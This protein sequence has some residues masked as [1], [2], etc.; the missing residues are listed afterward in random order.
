MIRTLRGKKMASLEGLFDEAGAALQLPY[1][2]GENWAAFDECLKDLSWLPGNG[3]L[4]V[5]LNADAILTDEEPEQLG[6]LARILREVCKEWS[7]PVALGESWDRPAKPFHVLWH[8][9]PD[10]ITALKGRTE[11]IG[12]SL[13]NLT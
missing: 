3:Y 12:L 1:Y 11:S 13:E 10:R 2:F 4:I 5:L 9:R 6:V 7:T 8:A